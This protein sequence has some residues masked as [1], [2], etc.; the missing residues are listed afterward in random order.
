MNISFALRLKQISIPF[1]LISMMVLFGGCDDEQDPGPVRSPDPGILRVL[2]SSDID[3]TFIVVAGDTATVGDGV[4]DSLALII[5]QARAYVDGKFALIF[6]ELDE[7]RE[8]TKTYNVIGLEQ[9]LYKE[10]LLYESFLSPDSYDSLGIV[11]T[12]DFLKIGSFQIPIAMPEGASVLFD[13]NDPYLIEENQVTEIRLQIKPFQSM[14]RVKD[15]FHFFRDIEVV[16][17]RTFPE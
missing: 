17:I 15:E 10:I 6:T 8:L 7:Y 3:D 14:V 12:A 9:G 4:S 5:G 13:F 16:D 11:I 2:I 1:F